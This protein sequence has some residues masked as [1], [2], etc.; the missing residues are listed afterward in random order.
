[1]GLVL[2]LAL[3]SSCPGRPP[4]EVG[5]RVRPGPVANDDEAAD[6]AL[7]AAEARVKRRPRTRAAWRTLRRAA[8]RAGQPHRTLLALE[9]TEKLGRLDRDL[10]ATLARGLRRRARN[11]ARLDAPSAALRTLAHAHRLAPPPSDQRA[12]FD[13]LRDRLTLQ[14]ADGQLEADDPAA[15]RKVYR[16]LARRAVLKGAELQWRRAALGE[17]RE[18]RAVAAALQ[19]L[20]HRAPGPAQRLARVYLQFG[21]RDRGALFA[22]LEAATLST[23]AQLVHGLD[24][25]LARVA[26]LNLLVDACRLRRRPR[27]PCC[28]QLQ[29]QATSSPQALWRWTGLCRELH[30]I[31]GDS[32]WLVKAIGLG[33]T[34]ANSGV[35]LGP[36]EGII[37]ATLARRTAKALPSNLALL[38]MAGQTAEL[39]RELR[40]PPATTATPAT[41]LRRGLEAWAAGLTTEA[42]GSLALAVAQMSHA[43]PNPRATFGP[44]CR[45]IRLTRLLQG[46]AAAY[47]L[48][49][50]LA[51]PDPRFRRHLVERLVARRELVAALGLVRP[52][53]D[54]RVIARLGELGRILARWGVA[55][56]TAL[57]RRW[58]KRYG[59]KL[60]QR[61]WAH[62][63]AGSRAAPVKTP[64]GLEQILR[65]VAQG[66][67]ALAAKKAQREAA[68]K[69][70]SSVRLALWRA[71]I[72]HLRGD[73]PTAH[74]RLRR[75]RHQDPGG[76]R[77]LPTVLTAL[78]RLRLNRAAGRLA[79]A[80][81]ERSFTDPALLR[82]VTLGAV[83]AGRYD[84]AELALTDWA[85]ATGRPDRA[86]LTVSRWLALR[87]QWNRAAVLSSRALGWRGGR[88]L[89]P[90]LASVRQHWAA[91]RTKEARRTASWLLLR[92]PAGNAR[93]G[94][95]Q[96][97]AASL[98]ATD[99]LDAARPYL[100]LNRG[101]DLPALLRKRRFTEVLRRAASRSRRE[102]LSGGWPALAALAAQ[103]LKQWKVAAR[104]VDQVAR[105]S[106][107]SEPLARAL[108][109]ADQGRTVPAL[110]AL[111]QT[112]MSPHKV[113]LAAALAARGG[114]RRLA[115]RLI[116]LW[117]LS[118]PKMPS[119]ATAPHLA[120]MKLL[121]A[122]RLVSVKIPWAEILTT[123][124]DADGC[125]P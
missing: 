2:A 95:S 70:K 16:E 92:W 47:R 42:N 63:V 76:F 37:P 106:P 48:M 43:T 14:R 53:H 66:D 85:S 104:Y 20:R 30:W 29:R 64:S 89:Q 91:L 23:D 12:A 74:R 56:D 75:L 100:K 96:T 36:L 40:R 112:P 79:D 118:T 122:G 77:R 101:L 111:A 59:S 73:Q 8:H 5:P 21:G 33:A 46:H 24:A 108:L 17:T 35:G 125:E 103:G 3:T 6:R 87:G 86:Y 119:E 117:I 113:R 15:A 99:R 11:L 81:Y 49:V 71:R 67:L 38:R 78:F 80:L 105:R 26:P 62:V 97:L 109:L 107:R 1:M 82:L 52:G 41:L 110:A 94:I 124:P 69:T 83:A 32:A 18:I 28:R 57:R 84:K 45:L 13:A 61:A 121:A 98:L 116:S 44:R 51:Q 39:R 19:R 31:P 88:P 4:P 115:A 114:K 22:A 102:P 55:G 93:N 65:L 34:R 54:A 7:A 9:A 10:Y 27:S 58:T 90:A 25:R 123:R 60:A 120:P 68:T 72:A 50:G